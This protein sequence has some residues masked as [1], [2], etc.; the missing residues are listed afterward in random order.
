MARCAGLIFISYR[1]VAKPFATLKASLPRGYSL[2]ALYRG[3]GTRIPGCPR[4]W[5]PS[6]Y[7]GTG[8]G[9]KGD[10]GLGRI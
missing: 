7:D 8:D 10:S 2:R 1:G 3:T 9:K 6:S 4:R 5:H